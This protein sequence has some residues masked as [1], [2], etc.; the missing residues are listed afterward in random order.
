[1]AAVAAASPRA[2]ALLR[3]SVVWDNHGCMPLRTNAEFLPQLERYR[4]NGVNVI[5][6]NVGFAQMSW[7]EHLQV[8]SYMRR[9]IAMQPDKY[10][11]V[12]R[13]DDV[14]QAKAEG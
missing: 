3:S 14:Q 6:L 1:M 9:W 5:S 8:L 13:V 4:A 7:P 12:A 11:L 10:R 2:E